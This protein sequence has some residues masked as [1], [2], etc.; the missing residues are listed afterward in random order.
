MKYLNFL[1]LLNFVLLVSVH[2]ILCQETEDKL[3]LEVDFVGLETTT[4]RLTNNTE[5]IIAVEVDE[6]CDNQF[7]Q[8]DRKIKPKKENVC[9]VHY[10][11]S[12][13][14]KLT[15]KVGYNWGDSF[16]I[17]TVKSGE[18]ILFNIPTKKLELKNDILIP[19]AYGEKGIPNDS[20]GG[21]VFHGITFI[22]EKFRTY[23]LNQK[24]KL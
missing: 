21:G 1:L 10:Y 13:R 2:N 20:Q 12:N 6:L 4:F 11:L 16:F 3:K 14:I 15:Q 18:S 17:I 5:K 19:F 9:N 7:N 22:W 24:I 23:K 8:L